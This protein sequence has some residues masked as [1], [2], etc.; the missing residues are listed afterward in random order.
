MRRAR[1]KHCAHIICDIF[2][3]WEKWPDDGLF[4]SHMKGRIRADVLAGSATLDGAA[5]E[6]AA[7]HGARAWLERDLAE[8]GIPMSAIDSA[9]L[10]LDFIRADMSNAPDPGYSVE[11]TGR[12]IIVSGSDRYE[13]PYRKYERYVCAL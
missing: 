8:N 7:L 12:G 5:Y 3:G 10:E 6:F 1:F 11:F 9:E 2:C 4:R 13:V